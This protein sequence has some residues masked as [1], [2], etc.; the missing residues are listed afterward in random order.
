MTDQYPDEL[1]SK[2]EVGLLDK[3]SGLQHPICILTIHENMLGYQPLGGLSHHRITLEVALLYHL[4]LLVK[5]GGK[6]L[7]GSICISIV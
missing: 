4:P 7:P 6:G 3:S 1:R 2:P 5:L